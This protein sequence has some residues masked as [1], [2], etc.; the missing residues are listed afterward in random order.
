M[1][2]DTSVYERQRQAIDS[3]YANQ[4]ATNAYSRFL[5]QQRSDRGIGDYRQS[6]QRAA[7]AYTAGYA[8]RGLAGA[9][10]QSGVYHNAM[11]NYV[12]DYTQNLNRQYADQAGDM[13]GY[14]LTAAQLTSARDQAQAQNE[15]DKQKEIALNAAYLTSLKAQMA[16]GA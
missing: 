13:R 6:F 12:G 16:G 5:S 11:R 7:P 10:V 9:G 3:N 14:D 1:A 4:T 8:K 2:I 15:I